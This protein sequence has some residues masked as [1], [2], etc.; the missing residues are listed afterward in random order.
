MI[1]GNLFEYRT[2]ASLRDLSQDARSQIRSR[3]DIIHSYVMDAVA[4]SIERHRTTRECVGDLKTCPHMAD[5][6]VP[7]GHVGDLAFRTRA[8]LVFG[9][10]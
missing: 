6:A 5:P 7:H 1:H 3:I 8:R 10:E 4:L 9:S 2:W